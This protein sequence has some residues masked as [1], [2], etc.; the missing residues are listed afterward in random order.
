MFSRK[1]ELDIL[2]K[3]K[4]KNVIKAHKDGLSAQETAD[5]LKMPKS[6]VLLIL[7]RAT[8]AGEFK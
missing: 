3:M 8:K 6:E 5:L 2:E 7:F 4:V 1:P